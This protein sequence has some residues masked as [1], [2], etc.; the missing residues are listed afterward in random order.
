MVYTHG[1]LSVDGFK[2]MSMNKGLTHLSA[3]FGLFVC[4]GWI[5]W[6]LCFAQ[7]TALSPY[8]QGD[9]KKIMETRGAAPLVVHFWGVTC[10]PC[11]TEMSQ[12]GQWVS[13]GTAPVIFVQV[14]DVSAEITAN[15]A[16]KM[17]ID[18]AKNY[19]VRSKFDE[20]LRFEIDA[21]WSGEIPYT[22]TIDKSGLQKAYSGNTNF[23]TLQSWVKNNS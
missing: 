6:S 1:G 4:L 5:S 17:K 16:K 8:A 23:K 22:V 13:K 10:G 21:K 2:L 11:L 3:R 7:S 12:W 14:D 19:F 15:L 18:K 20:F 9:W